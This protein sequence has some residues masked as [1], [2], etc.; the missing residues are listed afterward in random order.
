MLNGFF[1]EKHCVRIMRT[2]RIVS[3][4]FTC[5]MRGA[6]KSWLYKEIKLWY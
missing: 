1:Q 6:D 5:N 3:L 4:F 2:I